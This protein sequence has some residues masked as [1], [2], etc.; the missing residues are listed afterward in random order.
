MEITEKNCILFSGQGSQYS[1][2]GSDLFS[3]SNSIAKIYEAGSDILGFDLKD[4]CF[5]GDEKT[6]AQT[7]ISQPAIFA[8]SLVCYEAVKTKGITAECVCGHSLGE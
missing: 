5:N 3:K 1:G 4:I 2:M 6:L 7:Q 8:T